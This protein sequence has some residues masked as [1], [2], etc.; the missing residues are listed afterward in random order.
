M[1]ILKSSSVIN[2]VKAKKFLF[3]VNGLYKQRNMLAAVPI[4]ATI[5]KNYFVLNALAQAFVYKDKCSIFVQA[6]NLFDTRY[7]DLLGS[8]MPGRWLM[9]GFKVTL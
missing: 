5:S 2:L 9:G 1:K 3:S 7:S 4:N 8:K 6:D